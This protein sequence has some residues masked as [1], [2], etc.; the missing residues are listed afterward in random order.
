M[1]RNCGESIDS[2]PPMPGSDAKS[3]PPKQSLKKRGR[4][5][6]SR[7]EKCRSAVSFGLLKAEMGGSWAAMEEAYSSEIGALINAKPGQSATSFDVTQS[8]QRTFLRYG[9]GY[10]TPSSGT[11]SRLAWAR[12]RSTAFAAMFDSVLFDFLDLTEDDE[13][14]RVHFA[15]WLWRST[16]RVQTEGVAIGSQQTQRQDAFRRRMTV[17]LQAPRHYGGPPQPKNPLRADLTSFNGKRFDASVIDSFSI[18]QKEA[19]S[20]VILPPY[21]DTQ[22]LRCLSGIE[23]PDAL[24]IMLMGAKHPGAKPETRG[25]AIAGCAAWLTRWIRLFPELNKGMLF[26]FESIA[27]QVDELKPILESLSK[28]SSTKGIEATYRVGAGGR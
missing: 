13:G 23:H 3:A 7:G 17:F 4:P 25:M 18:T 5:T 11:G 16:M 15:C 24:C 1:A 14:A 28:K 20:W 21:Q 9:S 10:Q 8:E 19:P 6:I 26:F 27:L 22:Q 12:K 2:P